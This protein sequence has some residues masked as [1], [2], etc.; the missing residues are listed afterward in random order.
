MKTTIESNAKPHNGS[1]RAETWTSWSWKMGLGLLLFVQRNL[2]SVAGAHGPPSSG[3]D[4]D[5][6]S[7]PH[8]GLQLHSRLA[9]GH[10]PRAIPP[11]APPAAQTPRQH[12]KGLFRGRI[13]AWRPDQDAQILPRRRRVDGHCAAPPGRWRLASARGYCIHGRVQRGHELSA[14]CH[15]KQRV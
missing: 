14:R 11:P 1:L 3:T 9:S 7:A 8:H 6:S 13:T 2:K 15:G 10:Y 4:L 12:A 5:S